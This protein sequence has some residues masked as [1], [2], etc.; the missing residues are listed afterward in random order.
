MPWTS[1]VAIQPGGSRRP[2]FCVSPGAVFFLADLARHLG[3]DQ[4]FYGLQAQ[5]LHGDRP[6]LT[7]I[8][9][10]AT[11]YVNEIRSLQ[12]DGPY[13]LA[14]RCF[15]GAVAFELAQQLVAQGQ[16]VS[17]LII[18]DSGPPRAWKG[19]ERPRRPFPS[20]HIQR[21]IYYACRGEL[22]GKLPG[23]LLQKVRKV[24][25]TVFS[26]FRKPLVHLFSSPGKRRL[27]RLEDAN[28][29]AEMSYFPSIYPGR[30]TLIRSEEYAAL[31]RRR[32]HLGW[33][34]LA[35]EGLDCHV[36]AGTHKSM[37]HEPYV[38]SLAERLRACLD[39]AQADH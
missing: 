1:L 4:P 29:K 32:Y 17:L 9:D 18:L 15:G 27:Q 2:L 20:Y 16:K 6:P 22:R 24:P 28:R 35:T 7:R 19:Q 39:A 11:H 34:A 30:I 14:G 38:G 12:P 10:I 25:R 5:G 3:P 8:E 13:F 26:V 23:I 37:F 33:S 36:V 21:T 31:S